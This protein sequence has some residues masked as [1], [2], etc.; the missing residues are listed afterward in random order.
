M[1][2]NGEKT[3]KRPLPLRITVL[4]FKP[5]CTNTDQGSG[6]L[7][8]NQSERELVKYYNNYIFLFKFFIYQPKLTIAVNQRTLR[9][10]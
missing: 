4:Q 1:L 10:F 9:T 2:G 3:L 8:T 7:K 5:P 6:V